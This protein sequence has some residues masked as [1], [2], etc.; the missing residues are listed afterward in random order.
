MDFFINLDSGVYLAVGR[1]TKSFPKEM[2]L[3]KFGINIEVDYLSLLDKFK[4]TWLIIKYNAIYSFVCINLTSYD[5]FDE[6]L[7]KG[8]YESIIKYCISKSGNVRGLMHDSIAEALQTNTKVK[9]KTKQKA[10]PVP[11]MDEFAFVAPNIR[12]L[13]I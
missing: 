6:K 5:D 3:Y 4:E 2:A 10:T 13:G 12:K 1:F 7:E 9:F 11:D 8:V